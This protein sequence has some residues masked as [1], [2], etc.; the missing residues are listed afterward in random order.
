M[1]TLPADNSNHHR[2]LRRRCFLKVGVFTFAAAFTPLS[3]CA[4][5]ADLLADK[6]RRLRLYNLHTEERLQICYWKNGAYD[7]QALKAIDHILRDHRSGEIHSIDPRL[8]DLLH[9]ISVKTGSC[10]FHVISGYR[11]PATNSMLRKDD[12]QVASQS[13]HTLGKAVD[14]QM[15]DFDSRQLYREAVDLKS[16][17]AGYY[18]DRNFVHVDV[19]PVRCW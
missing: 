6:K 4:G 2:R 17:G 15:P 16:G 12:L 11:S 13:M 19:G 3:V 14:I 5:A 10:R 8:L 1:G 9:A 7:R 18:P